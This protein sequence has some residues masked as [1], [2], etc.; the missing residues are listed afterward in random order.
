MN[1]PDMTTLKPCKQT[2]STRKRVRKLV[3]DLFLSPKK[4]EKVIHLSQRSSSSESSSSSRTPSSVLCEEKLV[5]V[6]PPPPLPESSR[7]SSSSSSDIFQEPTA[8]CCPVECPP[9]PTRHTSTAT[10]K[11]AS[12]PHIVLTAP[13]MSALLTQVIEE[14]MLKTEVDCNGT[15]SFDASARDPVSY[16]QVRA[17]GKPTPTFWSQVFAQGRQPASSNINLTAL[18]NQEHEQHQAACYFPNDCGNINLSNCMNY[19]QQMPIPM[20]LSSIPMSVSGCNWQQQYTPVYSVRSSRLM[21]SGMACQLQN[22]APE[23]YPISPYNPGFYEQNS[24]FHDPTCLEC[25]GFVD[26]EAMSSSKTS[27]KVS[28]SEPKIDEGQE[29]PATCNL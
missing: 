6:E 17:Y 3:L 11:C 28:V 2:Q 22:Q 10:A 26:Y 25:G 20:S 24:G 8:I 5:S 1:G 7:C 14:T 13:E 9:M 15:P 12:E 18:T 19:Q 21:S 16:Q 27:K 23:P 4:T 29:T